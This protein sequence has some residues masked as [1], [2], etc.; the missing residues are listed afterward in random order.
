MI[1]YKMGSLVHQVL[2]FLLLLLDERV[3]ERVEE[4]VESW[5]NG[6]AAFFNAGVEHFHVG[7]SLERLALLILDRP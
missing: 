5:V 4:G 7:C 1:G 2:L 6:G 3:D